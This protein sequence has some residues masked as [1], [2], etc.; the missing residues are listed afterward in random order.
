MGLFW[1]E[2][3]LIVMMPSVTPGVVYGLCNY[4]MDTDRLFC[5]TVDGMQNTPPVAS[6]I[7][8]RRILQAMQK[9]LYIM[10]CFVA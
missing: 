7:E 5:Y 6:C 1:H 3:H 8:S 9:C 10:C 2:V 4:R